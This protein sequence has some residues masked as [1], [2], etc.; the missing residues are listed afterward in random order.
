MPAR[1]LR[2]LAAVVGLAVPLGLLAGTGSPAYAAPGPLS[3]CVDPDN[4]RPVV[5]AVTLSTTSADTTAGADAVDVTVTA[6]DAGGPGPASGVASVGL[7]LTGG[8]GAFATQRTVRMVDAGGGSWSAHVVLPRGLAPGDYRPQVTVVD[9][10]G[11]YR[12]YGAGSE[13][14]PGDPVLHVTS[15]ADRAAPRLASLRLSTTSVSTRRTAKDVVVRVHA[16]DARAGLLRVNVIASADRRRVVAAPLRLVSGT[17]ADG[18]WRGTL[19]IPRFTGTATWRIVSVGLA[20]RV[21][22]VR[23]LTAGDLA[24][25]RVDRSF[26]VRSRKDSAQP[27]ATRASFSVPAVDVT[28]GDQQVVVQVR[29]RDDAAGVAALRLRML[30]P[31]NVDGGVDSAMTRV[32]GTARDGIWQATVTFGQCGTVAG[33]W[34]AQLK[35]TDAAGRSRQYLSGQP[36]LAITARDNLAPQVVRTYVSGAPVLS[37]SEDVTGVTATSAQ[38]YDAAGN[39]AP[40]AWSCADGAGS[41]TS[42]AV[43]AVRTATYSPVPSFAPTGQL[44][45]EL[46]P[47]GSLGVTDLAG[48]PVGRR[49]VV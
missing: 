35:V 29:A 43:G 49:Y 37:F 6:S 1:P 11:S 38:V 40:G 2:T 34:T 14:V 22:N 25:A 47:D 5:T 15:V 17:A 3:P 20:D 18:R 23:N 10:A 46:N 16:T 42:C 9:G 27:S 7:Q 19:H 21:L 12:I 8:P 31:E 48:N 13:E 33:T 32:S 28:A 39:D 4:T 45:V 36:T 26:R 41:A 44:F 24:P 30:D